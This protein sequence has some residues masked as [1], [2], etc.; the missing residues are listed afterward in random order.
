MKQKKKKERNNWRIEE[1][2]RKREERTVRMREW[3][4][5]LKTLFP[6]LIEIPNGTAGLVRFL[7]LGLV[8]HMCIPFRL[9][10]FCFYALLFSFDLMALFGSPRAT[11]KE[12][13]F[14][15]YYYYYFN[16][17]TFSSFFSLLLFCF[18]FYAFLFLCSYQTFQ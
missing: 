13:F 9:F 17:Y 7:P 15:Y 4:N 11:K 18:I 3:G 8:P 2:E 16:F 14:S 12:F 6:F 1:R 5:Y 10:S